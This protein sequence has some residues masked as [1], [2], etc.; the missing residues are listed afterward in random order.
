MGV[1]ISWAGSSAHRSH[2]TFDEKHFIIISFEG[3]KKKKKTVIHQRGT[4]V[5]PA[6][7]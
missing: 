1:S 5:K 4:S 7:Y 2:Y 3:K 6:T